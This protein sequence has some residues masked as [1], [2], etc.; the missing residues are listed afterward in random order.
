MCSWLHFSAIL[1]NAISSNQVKHYTITMLKKR[2]L[3]D[4]LFI[5]NYFYKK[6]FA[7]IVENKNIKFKK[8]FI[9]IFFYH[10]TKY[11]LKVKI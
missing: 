6:S 2:N 11:D 1:E 7:F 9:K 4:F 8:L 3:S 5:E 10:F